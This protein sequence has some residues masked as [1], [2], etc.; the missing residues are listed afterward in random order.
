MSPYELARLAL[1]EDGWEQSDVTTECLEKYLHSQA[2]CLG[3]QAF[4]LIAKEQGVF[5]G[6]RWIEAVGDVT[7]LML[8]SCLAEGETFHAGQIL[9]RGLGYAALVLRA[10]RVLLNGLQQWCGVAT[11][12]RA[13]VQLVEQSA[14][15]QG[16]V[17]PGVYHTRKTLPLFRELQVEAVRAGGGRRH[18]TSLS[19]RVLF[20][21]NH[22]FFVHH[23]F[24]QF[25]KFTFSQA[26]YADAL[27]EVETTDEAL[28]AAQLGARALM[29]DNFSPALA[30]E[31][32]ARLP[33]GIEVEISGGLRLENLADYVL[34]G[35]TRL[36]LGSLT[37]SIRSIDIS[38]DW[39]PRSL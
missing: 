36:S 39:E 4:Y 5:S 32:L 10:E 11:R 12:T 2:A 34:P 33:K 26:E 28:L 19:E 21:E 1:R 31:T 37:H 22:K 16:M 29:L 35:V 13:C 14:L 17:A 25:L 9:C 30:Q 38:L 20:K 23:D 27:I 15:Q 7:G 24:A 8:R 18:R 3:A 6:S